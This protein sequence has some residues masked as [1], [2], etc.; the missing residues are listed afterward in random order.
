MRKH[1]IKYLRLNVGERRGVFAFLA[2]TMIFIGTSFL[3]KSLA[4][5]QEVQPTVLA[6]KANDFFAQVIPIATEADQAL[7]TELFA[8]DPNTA[9]T[10]ELVQLGLT[11][12]MASRIENYRTKGG[13][14]RQPEDFAK[15]YGLTEEDYERL[16]PFIQIVANES[17]YAFASHGSAKPKAILSDFD[18]N[19]ATDTDL[20]RLGLSAKTANAIL[21]YRNKGGK[22]RVAG[23]LK[24]IYALQP[25]DYAQLEPYIKIADAPVPV[26]FNNPTN[27]KAQKQSVV[28]DINQATAEDWQKIKGI[29]PTY[30]TKIINFRE[31]LGGFGSIDLVKETRGLPDSVFQQIRPY[32]KVSPI[33]QPLFI[34]IIDANTLAKHPLFDPKQA[35]LVYNYRK[36]NGAYQTID[37][38]GNAIPQVSR[39][40]LDKVQPYL[41]Y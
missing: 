33:N 10:Q 28:I 38:V 36:Q 15:I 41:K 30:A 3:V 4:P 32:L 26:M 12:A 14:F 8:F 24:K 5:N 1:M 22:F 6:E 31:K 21:N 7:P 37:Q 17:K 35:E 23:D 13:K 19:T 20:M 9:S 16:L 29:G 25:D 11:A 34:N 18:P 40:W 39:V 2:L 27:I